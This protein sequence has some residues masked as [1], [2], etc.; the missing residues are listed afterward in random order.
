[1]GRGVTLTA[2]EMP[3]F[4]VVLTGKVERGTHSHVAR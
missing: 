3:N 1:M 2:G 4:F